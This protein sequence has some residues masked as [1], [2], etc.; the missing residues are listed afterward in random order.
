M[1]RDYDMGPSTA[2]ALQP[3]LY[4]I[5]DAAAVLAVSPRTIYSLIESGVLP[6]VRLPGSGQVRQP[7]RIARMDL[8]R[9]VDGL[10]G[11]SA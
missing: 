7:V 2:L 1:M 9:F 6:A 8:M 4:R 3:E 5:R 10:R 11:A